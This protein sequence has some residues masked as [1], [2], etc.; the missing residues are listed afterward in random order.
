M[1]KENLSSNPNLPTIVTIEMEG[2]DD[3]RCYMILRLFSRV[4]CCNEFQKL[5]ISCF[6]IV[7][8]IIGIYK[9]PEVAWEYLQPKIERIFLQAIADASEYSKQQTDYAKDEIE[10]LISKPPT[11]SWH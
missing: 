5:P 3:T 4:T 10:F 2:V 9:N 8:N 7:G 11:D 1:A 6:K